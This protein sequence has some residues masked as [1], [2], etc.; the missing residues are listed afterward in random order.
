[1]KLKTPAM[2]VAIAETFRK[3]GCFELMRSPGMIARIREEID[4]EGVDV[5]VP[6]GVEEDEEV[7][8]DG[9]IAGEEGLQN[10]IHEIGELFG[11]IGIETAEEDEA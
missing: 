2:K 11:V 10:E 7:N 3:N 9:L 1:M 4:A 5:V 8:L 6:D